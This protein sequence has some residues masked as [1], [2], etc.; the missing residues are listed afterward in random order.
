MDTKDYCGTERRF[1]SR[2]SRSEGTGVTSQD[3]T[4]TAARYG[5]RFIV[6][7]VPPRIEDYA[8]SRSLIVCCHRRLLCSEPGLLLG[9]TLPVTFG[10]RCRHAFSTA[11]STSRP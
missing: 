11:A 5:L 8:S 4:A 7:H 1:R 9:F 3:R 2:P 6:H 10:T